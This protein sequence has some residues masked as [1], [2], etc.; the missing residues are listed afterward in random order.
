MVPI[1][2]LIKL[3]KRTR[4]LLYLPSRP[5]RLPS[6]S[7]FSFAVTVQMVYRVIAVALE[8]FRLAARQGHSGG[9]PRLRE[10]ASQ[11]HMSRRASI[12]P[13]VGVTPESHGTTLHDLKGQ[14]TRY[15]LDRYATTSG[16]TGERSTRSRHARCMSCS[17]AL[18][19]QTA[20]CN[21][22]PRAGHD[23]R[24]AGR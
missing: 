14:P 2:T 17:A 9:V 5:G 10:A 23:Q 18:T 19:L 24:G 3:K 8:R 15:T 13:H 4:T 1:G 21:A 11:L 20:S 12:F 16:G 22:S 6:T 7:C